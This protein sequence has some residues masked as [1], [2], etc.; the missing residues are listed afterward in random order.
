MISF[1]YKIHKNINAQNKQKWKRSMILR[2]LRILTARIALNQ[3]AMMK[4]KNWW[5]MVLLLVS[6]LQNVTRTVWSHKK[7]VWLTVTVWYSSCLCWPI[8]GFILKISY[9]Q[10]GYH[11]SIN[12]G[13]IYTNN[14]DP[15]L[16][17]G[18]Y[19]PKK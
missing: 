14:N 5:K 12:C 7:N 8:G 13:Y 17:H 4:T 9:S 6:I 11:D 10:R 19:Q 18:R 1:K 2:L 15:I 3:L 16:I